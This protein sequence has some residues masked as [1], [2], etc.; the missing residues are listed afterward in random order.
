[1]K[2]LGCLLIFSFVFL[3]F[4]AYGSSEENINIIFSG[5]E[6]GSLEPCGCFEGQIGGISRRHTLIDLLRKQKGIIFPVS[7]GDLS[8]N[9]GRQEEIKFEILCRAIGEMGYV[10][11][12]LGE[13]DIEFDPQLINYLSQINKIIFLS[14][15]VEFIEPFPVKINQYLI[16][17]YSNSKHSFKVAFLGI[18]SKSLL[19]THIPD[20]IRVY[21]PAEVLKILIK[22]LKDRADLL[23]LLSHAPLEESVEIAKSF[24]EI[25]LII[26]GH[27][28]DEPKDSIVHVNNIPVVSPGTGGKHV[29]VA[30][31]S[32]KNN[33]LERRSVEIIPLD[34]KYKD[35]QEMTSL[36]REYQQMLRDEDLLGRILQ[37]PLSDRLSY[38]GSPTCGICHKKVYEH[39]SKTKHGV[40][41]NTLVNDGYQYDPECIKCHTTGYGYVSGFLNYE[42]NRDLINVGCESCHGAGSEHIKNVNNKSYG[43]NENICHT[44]HDSEHSPKFKFDEYWKKIKHP[45]EILESKSSVSDIADTKH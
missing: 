34:R 41:Y 8:K 31:Y 17:E 12:N 9:F 15:N 29:G 40:S 26:T 1:M 37:I 2:P 11:H 43:F 7:L 3:S 24:P 20:Y 25:G 38:V 18:L 27:D 39:W 30:R 13:K 33:I 4:V 21:E 36:L 32:L 42:E 6:L 5:E 22:N 28:I 16:K 45:V 19:N 10:L 14:S 44:C 23:I 35:S